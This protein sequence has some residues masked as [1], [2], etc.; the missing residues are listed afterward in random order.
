[1]RYL[2]IVATIAVCLAV[3]AT[4][5]AIPIDLDDMANSSLGY[6][7]YDIAAGALGLDITI[8]AFDYS[9]GSQPHSPDNEGLDPA[10]QIRRSDGGWLGWFQIQTSSFNFDTDYGP[11]VAS[12]PSLA[13]ENHYEFTLNR[14][15]G[16]WSMALNGTVVDFTSPT[17]DGNEYFSDES[18]AARDNALAILGSNWASI[19]PEGLGGT[20]AYQLRFYGAAEGYVDDIQVSHVPEPV[21]MAGLMLGIGC[22]A[23]YVRNRRR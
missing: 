15:N 14:S 8:I 19:A 3:A 20:G 5:Q 12:A 18:Q 22:L 4:A 7:R 6:Y 10:F 17:P 11:S 2:G 21:T 16:R 13:G 9:Y 23:R 1:M